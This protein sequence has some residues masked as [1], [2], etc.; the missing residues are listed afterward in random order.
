MPA[1][2]SALCRCPHLYEFLGQPGS[3]TPPQ[4]LLVMF[5]QAAVRGLQEELGITAEVASLQG[6]LV[7]V[8]LRRLEAP[9]VGVTDCEFVTSF[10]S[11]RFRQCILQVNLSSQSDAQAIIPTLLVRT[12]LSAAQ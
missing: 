4:P 1:R 10:R 3:M 2:V 8:H 5:L 6:P 7:P 12:S 9:E 11:A